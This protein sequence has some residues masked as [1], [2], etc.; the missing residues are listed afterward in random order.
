MVHVTTKILRDYFQM[1]QLLA[2]HS[3]YCYEQQHTGAL[4]ADMTTS[5]EHSDKPV[6]R[7]VLKEFFSKD[8]LKTGSLSQ[9]PKEGL[10]TLDQR[11]VDAI[12][13]MLLCRGSYGTIVFDCIVFAM[14]SDYCKQDTYV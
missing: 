9:T 2:G 10:T 5:G 11:V 14:L 13:G 4:K 8:Q 6:A 3:V 7:F 1:V 12:L